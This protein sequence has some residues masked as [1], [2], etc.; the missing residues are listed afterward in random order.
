MAFPYPPLPAGSD[1]LRV[2]TLSPATGF[3]DPL[4]ATLE[5][6]PFS[7]KPKYIALSY[8]WADTDSEHA[9][10]PAMPEPSPYPELIAKC[11]AREVESRPS[12]Q[13]TAA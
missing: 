12:I 11:L 13:R 7:A 6:V 4:V 5:A 10:I 3:W 1:A 2:L 8:T 9:A